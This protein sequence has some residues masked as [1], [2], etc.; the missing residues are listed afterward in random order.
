M[1]AVA[2]WGS[3]AAP[4]GEDMLADDGNRMSQNETESG[5]AMGDDSGGG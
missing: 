3:A 2:V 1:F 5:T 4:D